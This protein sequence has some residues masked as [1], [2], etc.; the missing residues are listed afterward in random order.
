MRDHPQTLHLLTSAR[1][2][3]LEQV[4][5]ALEGEAQ[6][7][8][9]MLARVFSVASAR[10]QADERV[11]AAIDARGDAPELAALAGLLGRQPPAARTEHGGTPAAIDALSRLLCSQIRQGRF[12]AP[13]AGHEA[14]LEFLLQTTRAKL[15]E[16][17]PKALESFDRP[18]GAEE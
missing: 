17:N 4:V 8:A 11:F 14:L 5:P 7:T 12:D 13:A 18:K 9:L 15:A 3:L 16:S 2:A 6:G 1:R 10:L